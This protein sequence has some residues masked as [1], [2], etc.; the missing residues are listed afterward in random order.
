MVR[1]IRAFLEFCY[2][3]RR[4]I[5][6]TDSLQQL[7]DALARFHH[8]RVIFETS[9][10]RLDGF[11]L[12]RQHSLIHYFK[13]IRAFGAPNG[14]CS[15]ITE[16]KHIKA[17]KEPWRR[18]NHFDALGQMLLTNQR[19]DKLAAARADFQSRGMLSG[20]CMSDALRATGKFIAIQ[21]IC[22][23]IDTSTGGN[24]EQ[25]P[26]STG[27]VANTSAAAAGPTANAAAVAAAAEDDDNDDDDNIDVDPHALA[28]VELARTISRKY[29]YLHYYHYDA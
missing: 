10:V 6:D 27:D 2:I 9:G 20:T 1:T 11:N 4:D 26:D 8:Y 15:S 28:H 19:L 13:L 16:S 17:V 23:L 24:D 22:S 21:F 25:P 12:P 5:H 29:P 3:A 14:I 7:K 18:S